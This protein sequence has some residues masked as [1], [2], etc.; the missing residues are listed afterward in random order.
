MNVSS[1]IDE[2]AQ[3]LTIIIF[4]DFNFNSYNAFRDAYSNEKYLPYKI[5]I[6]LSKCTMLDSSALGMLLIMKKFLQK[7]DGEIEITGA[8]DVVRNVLN[9]V[10]FEKKFSIR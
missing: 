8:N 7:N 2:E 6:D 5:I 4:S 1:D 9:I 10:H 3:Q